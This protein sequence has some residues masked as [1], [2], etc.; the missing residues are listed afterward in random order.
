MKD[1]SRL[2]A[3]DVH[4]EIGVNIYENIA[5]RIART[6][7]QHFGAKSVEIGFDAR[8]TSPAYAAAASRGARDAGAN[9]MNIGMAVSGVSTCRIDLGFEQRRISGSSKPLW[10]EDEQEIWNVEGCR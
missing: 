3:Y 6:V 9:V 5:Y 8:E 2:K 7:A 4:G 10:S 1:L